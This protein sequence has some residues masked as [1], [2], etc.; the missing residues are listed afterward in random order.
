MGILPV[1]SFLT[2]FVISHLS[3]VHRAYKV[4]SYIS[5]ICFVI[6]GL[7]TA[8]RYF[9]PRMA[10]VFKTESADL[11]LSRH[12]DYYETLKFAN[13]NTKEADTILLIWAHG[14][15]CERKCMR[16]DYEQGVIPYDSLNTPEKLVSRLKTLSIDY[17]I[18]NNNVRE[19][20]VKSRTF[21][22]EAI[23]GI[24]QKYLRLVYSKNNVDLYQVRYNT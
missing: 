3:R 13:Q 24:K 2:A 4:I 5:L 9:T 15:Y 6:Y 20:G 21:P 14:Y 11:Y 18:V 1:L 10:V 7:G 23:D 12:Y 19:P 8:V 22:Y 16:G 17:I